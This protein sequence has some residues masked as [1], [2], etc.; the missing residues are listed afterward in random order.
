MDAIHAGIVHGCSLLDLTVAQ[1][2]KTF[3]VNTLAHFWLVRALLPS[4]LQSNEALIV[5]VSSVVCN[6]CDW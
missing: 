1:I 5:T 6:C 3:A 4:M 2:R